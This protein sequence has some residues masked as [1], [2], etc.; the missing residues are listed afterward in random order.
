MMQIFIISKKL[1]AGKAKT[2]KVNPSI[3]HFLSNHQLPATKPDLWNRTTSLPAD[4]LHTRA[5]FPPGNGN[6]EEEEE[7]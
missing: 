2:H 3:I 4:E 7:D 6:E 1:P 5:L